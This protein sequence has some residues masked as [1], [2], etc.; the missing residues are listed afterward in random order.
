MGL[1]KIGTTIGKEIIA[2]TRTG[3]SKSLLA[4][5]AIK[6]NTA[7]L[8]LAAKLE[9]DV[10]QIS[11]SGIQHVKRAGTILNTK[12]GL[13]ENITFSNLP[14]EIDR[15]DYYTLS[16]YNQKKER[17]GELSF[18]KLERRN[19]PSCLYINYFGTADGYKGIGSEMVRQL[20][21]LSKK[22]GMDGRV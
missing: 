16:A 21:Q 13:Q 17:I 20:V 2:W 12:T 11:N 1:D 8:R 18:K 4:T 7:R 6:V 10:V 3:A 9:H 14:T 15:L 22:L 5:K 19:K